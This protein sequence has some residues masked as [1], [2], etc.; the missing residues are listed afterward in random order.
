MGWIF[1]AFWC[2]DFNCLF[3]LR[4]RNF[5]LLSDACSLSRSAQWLADT[6][7][8]HSVAG[9]IAATNATFPP[10]WPA[11][12]PHVSHLPQG[13]Q[14]LGISETTLPQPHQLQ[15]LRVRDLSQALHPQPVFDW[16]SPHSYGRE[17]LLLPRVRQKLCPNRHAL[18]PRS[19]CPSNQL[20]WETTELITLLQKLYLC[21]NL[22]YFVLNFF[23]NFCV[24]AIQGCLNVTENYLFI[25]MKLVRKFVTK[26]HNFFVS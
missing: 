23:T 21:H 4:A 19:Q 1:F 17:A 14:S 13:F 24:I 15:T 22:V 7:E 26:C 20:D 18:S 9:T 5:L 8:R 10:R 12:Q 3:F 6:K 16:T 11:H 2:M 25:F